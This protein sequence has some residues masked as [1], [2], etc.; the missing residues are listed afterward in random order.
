[1][2]YS[3]AKEMFKL[4]KN[5]SV[6]DLNSAFR[7]LVKIYHPDKNIENQ[8]WSH[9]KMLEINSAFELLWEY[10]SENKTEV[11]PY[12]STLFE[13]TESNLK[14]NSFEESLSL[15]IHFFLN[16]I[17]LYYEYGLENPRLRKESIR[18]FRYREAR[19]WMEKSLR[20][21]MEIDG[22]TLPVHSIEAETYR[23]YKKFSLLIYK[24]IQQ[25]P[26]TLPNKKLESMFYQNCKDLSS[27]MKSFFLEQNKSN[28]KYKNH[29]NIEKCHLIFIEIIKKHGNEI[30]QNE[31]LFRIT[32]L[33]SFMELISLDNKSPFLKI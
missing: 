18:R 2:T 12:D 22:E 9:S 31:V 29:Y 1:M 7:N 19:K 5:F 28:A 6:E 13:N 33:E 11:N 24:E 16:G 32:L 23:V 14:A 3:K 21:T 10:R 4:T 27:L 20:H 25:P 15:S 8:E 30:P 26:L 17:T